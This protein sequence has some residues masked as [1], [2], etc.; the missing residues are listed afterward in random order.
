M[1]NEEHI[2]RL[3]EGVEKWN[4]WRRNSDEVPD[5]SGAD[6]SRTNLSWANLG[7]A[8][9]NQ[10]DLHWTHLGAADLSRA[11][12]FQADL[13]GAIL[14]WAIL[15]WAILGEAFLGEANL[16][17]A[18][19]SGALLSGAQF[20]ETLFINVNLS[21]VQGL[22]SCVH[23]GPSTIDHRT[24]AQSGPLPLPFL[25]GCGLPYKLI[26][27]LPSLLNESFQ[28]Y[29][30]FISYSTKDQGFAE[31]LHNDLQ[32]NGVRCWFALEDLKIGDPFR[33]R[34]DES[35]KLHDKLLLILSENS[36]NS[37]WVASEVEAAFEREHRENNRLVLFPVRLDDGVMHTD[38]AWA[39]DIR[40]NQH[41]GDFTRW[42]DHES[43]QKA[44][45]RLLRDL[46][47]GVED[48]KV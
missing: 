21:K 33:Q 27:Y 26:E 22:G 38:Q 46:K 44:F 2:K 12:L 41:I 32:A 20:L 23:N 18:I 1:D 9:L 17:G 28:F 4:D 36:I 19:F 3:R 24:L 40:R 30:C 37:P 29:S 5:L 31:R 35:I 15:G 43:Y 39:A 13:K 16:S 42:K 10:A 47:A 11:N 14:G 48:P 6:L 25:R 8:D 45:K 7:G 34:I